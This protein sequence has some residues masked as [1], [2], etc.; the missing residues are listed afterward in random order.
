M[1]QDH[2]SGFQPFNCRRFSGSQGFVKKR[3][4]WKSCRQRQGFGKGNVY[5]QRPNATISLFTASVCMNPSMFTQTSQVHHP[6][7]TEWWKRYICTSSARCHMI[8]YIAGSSTWVQDPR[9]G[10]RAIFLAEGHFVA[11]D[12]LPF[13]KNGRHDRVLPFCHMQD[14]MWWRLLAGRQSKGLEDVSCEDMDHILEATFAVAKMFLELFCTVEVEALCFP[15][16]IGC[17]A[18]HS[19][20]SSGVTCQK[21][22]FCIHVGIDGPGRLGGVVSG[23]FQ[24]KGTKESK[25]ASWW[26]KT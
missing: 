5:I 9:A 3:Q 1:Q 20:S 17:C 10:G 2:F 12:F 19:G 18:W 16:V 13:V 21:L 24:G 22:I 7:H 25:S 15:L 6:L 26:A 11:R 8:I 14:A 23:W 4:R